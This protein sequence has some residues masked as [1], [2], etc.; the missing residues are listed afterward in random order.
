VHAR[1]VS[2]LGERA[3]GRMTKR[4]SAKRR[5][6]I[7]R[8]EGRWSSPAA[9]Y[10][11]RPEHALGR[12]RRIGQP[13]KEGPDHWIEPGIVVWRGGAPGAPAAPRPPRRGAE[14][15]G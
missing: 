2:H 10:V 3:I 14:T 5:L 15:R 6:S 7:G 1:S 12:A 8:D 13:P 9:R 11:S 4:R